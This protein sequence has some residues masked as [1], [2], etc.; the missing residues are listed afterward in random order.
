MD[1]ESSYERIS[2]EIVMFYNLENLFYPADKKKFGDQ[3]PFEGSGKWNRARYIIKLQHLA[4]TFEL[5][6][7]RYH[8]MP[9]IAGVCEVQ[10]EKPLFDLL[11]LDP[12]GSMFDF[13]HYDS[14]D[15][16]GIDVALLYD[17]K[18]VQILNS[19][20]LT[21]I[22]EIPDNNPENY[23]TT[24][25]VLYVKISFKEQI[26]NVFVVHLP[27]KRE[28]DVNQPK[29]NFI[30][31]ELKKKVQEVVQ[32]KVE[33]VIILGD[34]NTNPD[35]DDITDLLNVNE[36]EKLVNPFLNL[37]QKDLF[38]TYHYANGLLF[39]QIIFSDDFEKESGIL[40][41]QKAEVFN[42]PQ[43]MSTDRKFSG[44]PFR[45]YAG[46]RYLGG[47]SDHFPVV[48]EFSLKSDKN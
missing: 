32:N 13:V 10:G 17:K 24:R 1:F 16:R 45:T 31:K 42:A 7:S 37:Y 9:F 39:D 19:E 2:P 48:A 25:D 18:S 44:R 22:F 46:S 36:N 41:F 5:V 21:F 12:F 30:L 23:D 20:T 28:N 11:N 29:R 35:D 6:K 33:S 14:M 26:I 27:S 8:T 34:F 4:Q 47:Y 15:E 3:L 43:L 38:S 40:K